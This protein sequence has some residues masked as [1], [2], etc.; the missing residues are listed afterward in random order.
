MM[1][2]AEEIRDVALAARAL[3][4]LSEPEVQQAIA[5]LRAA[6][7]ELAEEYAPILAR[8]RELPD[9]AQLIP[10]SSTDEHD[11][12]LAWLR[13]EQAAA[14]TRVK[15]SVGP[16]K[17]LADT[18]HAAFCR[19]EKL[20][21]DPAAAARQVIVD[22]ARRYG[23]IVEA[24]RRE[25]ERRAREEAAA[26]ERLARVHHGITL[27]AFAISQAA[28]VMEN[29]AAASAAEKAG[30]GEKA[31]ELRTQAEMPLFQ[32]PP[33][34]PIVV[35]APAEL[36][37]APKGLAKNWKGRLSA[38]DGLLRVVRFIANH[39]EWIHLLELSQV[40]ADR[41]AKT[42]EAR[43]GQVVDGLEGFNEPTVRAG[44]RRR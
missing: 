43:L 28:E 39:P 33:P 9:E 6:L 11:F 18:V 36:P 31:E 22:K 24:Q 41:A 1:N 42:F 30:D 34:P 14:V 2:A 15:E 21:L 4:V 3:P 13:D 16:W 19:L 37:E 25:A 44:A 10:I 20:A 40:H 12:A 23:E 5:R 27:V 7:E 26:A 38:T 32:Q 17:K 8:A 29:R 35:T